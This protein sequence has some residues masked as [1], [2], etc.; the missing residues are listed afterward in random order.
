M[1]GALLQLVSTGNEGKV[2]I[3]NPQISFFKQ[4]FLRHTN[5]SIE[6]LEVYN[7]GT[8][9]LKRNSENIYDFFIDPQHGDL[10]YYVSLII[11]LPAIYVP[12]GYQFR[13]IENLGDSIITDAKIIINGIT[14]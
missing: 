14:K 10:L 11:S 4:S 1:T 5:F 8:S 2:F 7:A 13:W 12:D 9:K 6:R 3:G